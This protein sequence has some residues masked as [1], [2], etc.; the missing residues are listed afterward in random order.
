MRYRKQTRKGKMSG[1]VW[2]G[3]DGK[4]D[5]RGRKG[6]VIDPKPISSKLKENI[7]FLYICPSEN[8]RSEV[9]S[10]GQKCWVRKTIY[11]R[12]KIKNRKGNGN[13]F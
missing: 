9:S 12:P 1:V 11:P 5:R 13:N 7:A 8:K 2:E 6:L 3:Q 4:N 10:K